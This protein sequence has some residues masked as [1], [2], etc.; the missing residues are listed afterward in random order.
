MLYKTFLN[1]KKNSTNSNNFFCECFLKNL[2]NLEKEKRENSE[3][4]NKVL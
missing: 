1:N 3:N 2:K 4:F